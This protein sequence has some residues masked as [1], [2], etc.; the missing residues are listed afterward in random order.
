MIIWEPERARL[1]CKTHVC[2]HF[3]CGHIHVSEF[4]LY[5]WIRICIRAKVRAQCRRERSLDQ[6]Q[7]KLMHAWQLRAMTE[8]G[9]LLTDGSVKPCT[10]RS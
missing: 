8:K 1:H 3:V 10:V 5:E 9:R 4:I 6:R 7:L 2:L